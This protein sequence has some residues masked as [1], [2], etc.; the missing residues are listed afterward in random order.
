LREKEI[1]RANDVKGKR[2]R[3]IWEGNK[4]GRRTERERR[5]IGENKEEW[6]ERGCVGVGGGGGERERYGKGGY[7]KKVGRSW[8][9]IYTARSVASTHPRKRRWD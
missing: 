9:P 6:G 8:G 4:E 3:G 5:R 7:R 1:R 2:K